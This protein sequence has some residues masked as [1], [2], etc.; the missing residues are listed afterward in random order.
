MVIGL[1][2]AI[3]AV[4]PTGDVF[5]L[6]RYAVIGLWIGVGAPWVFVKARLASSDK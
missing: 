1:R 2:F 5:T 4:L 6:V 3:K